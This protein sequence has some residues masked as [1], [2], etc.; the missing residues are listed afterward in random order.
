[1]SYKRA[2]SNTIESPSKKNKT[3]DTTPYY[4][5]IPINRE[6][7]NDS[8]RSFGVPNTS[9]TTNYSETRSSDY[10]GYTYSYVEAYCDKME[11]K[12]SCSAI[13]FG[14]CNNH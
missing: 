7:V 9:Y 2:N 5:S 10:G 3:N 1:M 8:V 11:K 14:K 13:A 4:T 12:I 6:Y